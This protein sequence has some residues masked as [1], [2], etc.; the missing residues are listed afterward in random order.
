MN[1]RS[2][3]GGLFLTPF[4][5]ALRA[6]KPAAPLALF[7]DPKA[8]RLVQGIREYKVIIEV[9]YGYTSCWTGG[10]RLIQSY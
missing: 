7:I 10:Q 3:L 1:R 9:T 2:F 6:V 5:R 8:G 4:A